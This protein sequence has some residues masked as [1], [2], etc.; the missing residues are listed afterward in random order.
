M[1]ETSG[2]I[3]HMVK[4]PGTYESV[5]GPIPKTEMKVVHTETRSSMA[6]RQSGKICMRGPQVREREGEGFLICGFPYLVLAL[7]FFV[8][9]VVATSCRLTYNINVAHSA[10]RPY[11]GRNIGGKLLVG[12]VR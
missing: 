8:T 7:L 1:T 6:A 2:I 11:A 5:G 9:S 10:D 3:S 4:G 12:V